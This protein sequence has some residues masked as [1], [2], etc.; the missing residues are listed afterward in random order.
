MSIKGVAYPFPWRI[1][2]A[3]FLAIS[4]GS[5]PALLA[6]VIFS[7]N[8]PI[9]PLMLVRAL[10]ILSVAPGVA[11]WLIELAFSVEVRVDAGRLLLLHRERR[12]E[13]PC[14]AI[15]RVDVWRVPLPGS[16]VW[17]RRRTGRRFRYGLQTADPAALLAALAAAGGPEQARTA[18][19]QP[20]AA[21]ASAKQHVRRRRWY[22]LLA[23]YPGFAL[24]PTLPL[25]RVHQHI[26]YG[27]TFG[28]YYLVGLGAYLRTFG[29][30]WGTLTLYLVL[31][32]ALWRGIAETVAFGA[33]LAAPSRAARVRRAVEI[34]HRIAYYGSV[35]MLVVIRF[36]PW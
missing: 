10:L 7:R 27:G 6:L 17:L 12:V 18:M 16:G 25:F 11:A 20:A 23:K 24:V 30:Y 31:Y 4:R 22:H 34:G 3:V 36:L 8:P 1:I 2:A 29:V 26:A 5:L 21:Y 19:R 35:P 28:Q 9:M 32:G 14:S 15:A 33:A 13:I